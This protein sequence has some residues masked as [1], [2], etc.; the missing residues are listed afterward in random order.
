MFLFLSFLLSLIG[1]FILISCFHETPFSEM[2]LIDLR[3]PMGLKSVATVVERTFS[4]IRARDLCFFTFFSPLCFCSGRFLLRAWKY[5]S[6]FSFS[7]KLIY[8]ERYDCRLA[9]V[10]LSFVVLLECRTEFRSPLFH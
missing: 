4:K 3:N 8:F 5:L 7:K 1:S 10:Q 6:F 9:I 2:N